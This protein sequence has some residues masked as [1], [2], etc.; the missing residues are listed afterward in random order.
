VIRSHLEA[1]AAR[2]RADL[3]RDQ[4]RWQR[5]VSPDEAFDVVRTFVAERPS[6]LR[7]A[8]QQTFA[9]SND[10]SALTESMPD[11]RTESD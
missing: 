6:I 3:M 5:H 1:R 7:A 9:E 10:N 11:V 4:E 8:L 2:V